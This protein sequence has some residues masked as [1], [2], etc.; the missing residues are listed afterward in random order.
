[1][2]TRFSDA[3]VVVVSLVGERGREVKI[4]EDSLGEVGLASSGRRHASR[5]FAADEGLGMLASNCYR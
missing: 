2:I 5:H 1:M 4:C 3:D